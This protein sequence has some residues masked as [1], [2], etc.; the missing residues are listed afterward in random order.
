MA[1]RGHQGNLVLD[2]PSSNDPNDDAGVSYDESRTAKGQEAILRS[3][4]GFQE[5]YN[6]D[7][8]AMDTYPGST[9]YTTAVMQP[10]YT[11]LSPPGYPPGQPGGYSGTAYPQE[12]GYAPAGN[13]VPGYS[14]GSTQPVYNERYGYVGNES[15]RSMEGPGRQSTTSYSS[16][17]SRPG[18][19][20]PRQD[21]RDVRQDPRDIRNEPRDP[22]F[23][24]PDPR[25]R[26]DT[27][28][29]RAGG[30]IESRTA[31]GY[32]SYGNSP[33]VPMGGYDYVSAMPPGGGGRGASAY[34]VDP[35]YDPRDMPQMRE[36]RP[37]P[38]REEQPRR[39]RR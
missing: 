19:A 13:Y 32:P 24:A 17:S 15:P 4:S 22:R 29:P 38:L 7:P 14:T 12:S 25:A 2:S 35:G 34:T 33:D 9:P 36:Y 37:E 5:S 30:R 10:G 8:Y 28:D 3:S 6:K 27:R 18:R 11:T 16:G 1:R 20:D 31:P 23:G 21:P 39:N 26:M